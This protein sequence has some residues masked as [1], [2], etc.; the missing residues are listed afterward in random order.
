MEVLNHFSDA[1][2]L[3][4]N[5]DKSSSYCAGIDDEKRRGS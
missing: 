5:T 3:L 1:T 4:A 2:G